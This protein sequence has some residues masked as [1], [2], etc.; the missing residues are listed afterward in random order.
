[1]AIPHADTIKAMAVRG[2][3]VAQ[4]SIISLAK[5][6]A[7]DPTELAVLSEAASN[8]GLFFLDLHGD[9]AGECVLAHL[10]DIYAVGEKYFSQPP[11]AKVKDSRLDIKPS[12]DLG[13]K[14]GKGAESFEVR[15]PNIDRDLFSVAHYI[16]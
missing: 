16:S 3:P 10:S 9:P 1:M 4:L 8:K 14:E 5:L 2:I 6:R 15:S 7:K 12:Q 13:W 11:E